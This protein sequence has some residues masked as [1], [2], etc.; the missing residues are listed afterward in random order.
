MV[1]GVVGGLRLGTQDVN[2]REYIISWQLEKGEV[3]LYAAGTPIFKASGTL[4]VRS[5]RKEVLGCWKIDAEVGAANAGPGMV[6]FET[7]A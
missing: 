5:P 3:H 4:V 6:T 1:C 7:G 2:G